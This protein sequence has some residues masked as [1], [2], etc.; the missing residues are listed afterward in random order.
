MTVTEAE[1]DTHSPQATRMNRELNPEYRSILALDASSSQKALGRLQT[2]PG[3]EQEEEPPKVARKFT[4]GD[5]GSSWRMMKL[6]RVFEIAE[7]ESR[8]VDEVV[9]E[10]Y[11]SFDEFDEAQAE[12]AF[13]D[14]KAPPAKRLEN[15]VKAAPVPASK[16]L[17]PDELRQTS[18][19]ESIELPKRAMPSA[20]RASIPSATISG[21][22]T[23]GF[24]ER[25]VLSVDQLNKLKS[26]LLKAKMMGL[27]DAE[28]LETQYELEKSKAE[29]AD[30][31]AEQVV[32]VSN[33]DSRGRLI[34]IAAASTTPSDPKA[35]KVILMIKEVN[36]KLTL[37][38]RNNC[39]IRMTNTGSVSST[40][41]T[42]QISH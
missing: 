32:V 2:I 20:T 7:A 28:E 11:G 19:K 33:V 31:S 9:L 16:F 42:M 22:Q 36:C 12:R 29:S 25:S 35:G 38:H 39:K 26:K 24:N 13:L 8:P 27:P 18:Q 17:A 34:D 4:F 5:Q 6:R 40:L 14:G 15:P 23:R 41:P 10:R 37:V 3:T 21:S 30:Q 1:T